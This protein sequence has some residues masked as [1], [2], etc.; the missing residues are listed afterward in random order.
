MKKVGILFASVALALFLAGG[1]ALAAV[2]NGTAGDDTL[3]GTNSK[4]TIYGYEGNDTIAG[5]GLGDEIW[6]GTGSDTIKGEAGF[7]TLHG[8][9]GNDKLYGAAGDDELRGADGADT[10]TGGD[11]NDRLYDRD[12]NAAEVDWFYCGLGQDAVQADPNDQL[13]NCETVNGDGGADNLPDLGMGQLTNVQI[14]STTTDKRLRFDTIIANVGSGKFEVTGRRPDANTTDMTVTQRIYDSNGGY[15]DR[16][17]AATFFYS[18]DGHEHWHV[19]DLEHY[20]LFALD[21]NG[22]VVEKT[23]LPRE[24]AKTGF[25]FYDNW[26]WGSAAP[27]Y[28]LGCENGNPGALKV[29]MGL[30]RGWADEYN[31]RLPTQ[32]IPITGLAD[33]NYR[34]HVTADDSNWFL[35]SDETNNFTWADLRITG[36]TVTVLRYGPSAPKVVN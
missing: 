25:C 13:R 4:D 5:K 32:Y 34:L 22:N 23:G 2:V 6:G 27:A 18:G 12:G 35:E 31:H 11:G 14:Q 3:Y 15:R 17:A 16:S 8:E 20:Q 26:N 9:G 21:A 7:D 19:R 1:V 33:G 28:Y 36:T 24:G 30:T 10:L 29:T